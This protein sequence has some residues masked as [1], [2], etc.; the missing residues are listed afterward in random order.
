V[1]FRTET[2]E[3]LSILCRL[4]DNLPTAAYVCDPDGRIVHFNSHAVEL[5]G[6]APLLNDDSERY[7]GSM[8]LFE[9]DGTPLLREN[10]A[11]AKALRERADYHGVEVIVERPDGAVRL[12]LAHA[13]PLW[14]DDGEMIGAVNII[15]DMTDRLAAHEA[16]RE[17]EARSRL[18]FESAAD[19]L[20][21]HGRDARIS[22]V[23][24]TACDSLGYTREELLGMRVPEVE[25]GF[26]VEGLEEIWSRVE[27]AGTVTVEGT[28][29]RKDGSM[30]PVEVRLTV[31]SERGGDQM[32]AAV[33]DITERKRAEEALRRSEE[34]FRLYF[35]LGLVGMAISSPEKGWIQFND[36][37]C[38]MLGYTRAELAALS[39]PEIT[40]PDDLGKDIEQ[41][42]RLL[43]GE[44][45]G[46]AIE[47]RYVG[48]RGNI[49][50][51]E[52]FVKCVRH[53]D[54]SPD[55]FFG[56]VQDIT[57]RKR[58]EA[59]K[60][61][62][63][64]QLLQAQ[65]LEAVGQLAGGVAHDFNN[66][67]QVITGYTEFAREDL[68]RG[69]GAHEALGKVLGASTRAAALVDQL[70]AFS[71]RQVLRR[72]PVDL[73]L[74][75]AGMVEMLSRVIGEHIDLKFKPAAGLTPVLADVNLIEQVVMNLCVNARDAIGTKGAITIEAAN[76]L[77]DE[78]FCAAH[79]GAAP[80][81]YVRISVSDT[82]A[83]M[84]AETLEHIFEPFFT[85]KD[86]S[87]GC[88]LGLAT[89][90]GIVRQHEG[91]IHACSEPG[92]GTTM[93]VYLPAAEAPTEVKPQPAHQDIKGGAEVVLI[94][95]D[96]EGVR[97]LT[98]RLLRQA[99][100]TVLMAKDGAEAVDIYREHGHEIDLL[101]FDVVMPRMGGSEALK[102]IRGIRPD[103]PVVFCSGYSENAIHDDFVLPE[104]MRLVQKPYKPNDLL[105][106]IRDAI[107]AAR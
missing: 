62:L 9:R 104:G 52:L 8:R 26:P 71:R 50:D 25:I 72:V 97:M 4:L 19:A 56:L 101:L 84:D 82:G 95:E 90:Y 49:V 81:S 47:K 45:E 61:L 17:S 103:M 60:A 92:R 65:K 40:H 7:C 68:P 99:G 93:S 70:L 10:Y 18:L 1:S 38:D 42:D 86:K 16:L 54:G 29:R 27:D 59:E 77:L 69:H 46:Y 80:G 58:G 11:M 20:F 83:G 100:Y 39:W 23:N 98:G 48:K 73:N 107:E 21:V 76:A 79:P 74:L 106:E 53:A 30:F 14:N 63:Q 41:F 55:Y 36:R 6:R 88:G 102:L 51:V 64:E 13:H 5:W 96:D 85:T 3:S 33:R 31:F 78:S 24:Q 22:D 12:G 2:F 67:L 32:Y 75:S 15:A 44:I 35:D 91:L 43:R 37:F 105:R 87:R 89:A 57:G 34:R 94:A 66:L 28:H